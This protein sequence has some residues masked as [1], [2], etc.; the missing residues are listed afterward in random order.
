LQQKAAQ[1]VVIRLIF[2]KYQEDNLPT[3]LK[4]Y[5]R[6]QA[7]PNVHAKNIL[8]DNKQLYI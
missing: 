4:Q 2:G 6:I 3:D 5:T 7:D 1:G 8:I